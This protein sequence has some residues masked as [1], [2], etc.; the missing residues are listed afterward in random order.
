[1]QLKELKE[2]A[3]KAAAEAK[4]LVADESDGRSQF[5][6]PIRASLDHAIELIGEHEKWI[7]ANAAPTKN[8]PAK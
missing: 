1:M 6:A 5:A 8:T 7:A 3:A 2:S 4:K